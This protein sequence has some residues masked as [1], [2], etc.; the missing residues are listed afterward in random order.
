MPMSMKG[1]AYTPKMGR[2][3]NRTGKRRAFGSKGNY[4]KQQFRKAAG[5]KQIQ[6][7]KVFY[8]R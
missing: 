6:N 1:S 2:K 7:D 3:V 5:K 4:P 8:N